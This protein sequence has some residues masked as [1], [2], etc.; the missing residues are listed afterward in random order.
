[1]ETKVTREFSFRCERINSEQHRLH[2]Q[3]GTEVLA[4]DFSIVIE[5][6]VFTNLEN[7]LLTLVDKRKRRPTSAFGNDDWCPERPYWLLDNQGMVYTWLAEKIQDDRFD[8][9][10]I[11]D[12]VDGESV[13][14][15]V[16]TTVD[17]RHFVRAFWAAFIRRPS[18]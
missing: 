18:R 9:T 10:I 8:L 12:F 16:R 5:H 17:K 13:E 15:C 11:D 14:L 3:I 1:M 7:W 4:I 6:A 2:T